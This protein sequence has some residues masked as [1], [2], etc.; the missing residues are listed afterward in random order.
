M[1][2]GRRN[3]AEPPNPWLRA[4]GVLMTLGVGAYGVSGLIHG[5]LVNESEV[6]E[7]V[8]ARVTGAIMVALASIL[9]ARRLYPRG[10]QALAAESARDRGSAEPDAAPDRP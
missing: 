9:L 6:L 4:L 7:G 8:P 3:R 2:G 1:G 5:R 10:E